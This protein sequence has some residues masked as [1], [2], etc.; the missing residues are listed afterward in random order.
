MYEYNIL[1]ADLHKLDQWKTIIAKDAIA[2]EWLDNSDDDDSSDDDG[3]VGDD[4]DDS[5]DDD[6]SDDSDEMD[7][8]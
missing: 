7:T 5:D 4:S 6:D 3:T 8:D 1:F 2:H